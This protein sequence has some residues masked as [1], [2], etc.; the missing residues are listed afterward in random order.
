MFWQLV[1]ETLVTVTETVEL[2]WTQTSCHS[3]APV[4]TS[5]LIVTVSL[6][7]ATYALAD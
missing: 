7:G 4:A 2:F 6:V 5:S 1:S 3:R